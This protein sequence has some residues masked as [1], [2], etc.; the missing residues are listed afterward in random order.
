MRPRFIDSELNKFVEDKLKGQEGKFKGDAA[1][2]D[3]AQQQKQGNDA[4]K[5]EDNKGKAKL[6]K[7]QDAIRK[8]QVRKRSE[9][10]WE[11][12]GEYIGHDKTSIQKQIVSH[13]EYTLA[14]SRFDFNI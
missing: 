11:L 1:D 7:D 5:Q 10:L 9:K 14:K 12:M 4:D 2:N 8:E 13:I 6:K 3:A